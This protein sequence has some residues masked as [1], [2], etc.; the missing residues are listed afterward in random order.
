VLPFKTPS[1][2]MTWMMDYM[3]RT[4]KANWYL[5]FVCNEDGMLCKVWKVGY[6]GIQCVTIEQFKMVMGFYVGQYP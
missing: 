3:Y 1:V 6:W 4:Q 2:S 5:M